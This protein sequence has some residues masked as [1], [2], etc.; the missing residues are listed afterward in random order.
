MLIIGASVVASPLL[1]PKTMSQKTDILM[2]M[3]Y[4]KSIDPIT[5][6]K[7]YGCFRLAPRIY[8]LKNDG[9]NIKTHTV[10]RDKKNF[11]VYELL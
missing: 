8:D 10:T 4:H 11:A 7:K 9:Y 2:H 6:L 5:A 3:K 1:K